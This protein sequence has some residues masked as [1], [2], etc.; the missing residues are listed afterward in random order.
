LGAVVGARGVRGEGC[1]KRWERGDRRWRARIWRGVR[2]GGLGWAVVKLVFCIGVG[3][4]SCR[5]A[6]ERVAP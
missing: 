1:G 3:D 4:D 2:D 5:R 6:K